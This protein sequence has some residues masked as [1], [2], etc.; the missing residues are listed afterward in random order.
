MSLTCIWPLCQTFLQCLAITFQSPCLVNMSKYNSCKWVELQTSAVAQ[1]YFLILSYTRKKWLGSFRSADDSSFPQPVKPFVLPRS[2][3]SPLSLPPL[4]P[5][6][7]P[8]SVCLPSLV[9]FYVFPSPICGFPLSYL[10]SSPTCL[11]TAVTLFLFFCLSSLPLVSS[12]TEVPLS[13]LYPLTPGLHYSSVQVMWTRAKAH[14]WATCFI[15]WAT[16]TSA[17]C[18]S[19][20]RSQRRRERLPSPMLGSWMKLARRGTGT[21]WALNSRRTDGYAWTGKFTVV[22][23]PQMHAGEAPLRIANAYQ[24]S[25]TSCCVLWLI[26]YLESHIWSNYWCYWYQW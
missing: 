11:I 7:V 2:S 13:S 14:W 12:I 5:I 3:P 18:T 22:L 17:P 1:S 8:I 15:C 23:L 20:S 25:V 4:P 26:T 16:S 21:L 6:L 19:T 9:Q 10:H 24:A